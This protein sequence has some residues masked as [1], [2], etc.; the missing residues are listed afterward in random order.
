MK[1]KPKF[2]LFTALIF[3]TMAC[4]SQQQDAAGAQDETSPNPD[5]H[6]SRSSLDW[7]GT[8]SC[9]VPCADCD[10]ISTILSLSEDGT[11]QKSVEYLGKADMRFTEEG[12]FEWNGAGSVVY[13]LSKDGSKPAYQVAEN[14]LYPLDK[15]GQRLGGEDSSSFVLNKR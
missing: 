8:Y 3:N 6:D 2:I 11:F 13:L 15:N 9:T 5:M 10:G 14:A 12:S 1:W 4:E 7:S